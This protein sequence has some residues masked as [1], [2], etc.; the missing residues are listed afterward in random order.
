MPGSHLRRHTWQWAPV[1]YVTGGANLLNGAQN[2]TKIIPAKR[3]SNHLGTK[4]AKVACNRCH[5]IVL[6]IEWNNNPSTRKGICTAVKT[7]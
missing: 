3:P 1:E 7:G 5:L 2:N 4:P 6:F